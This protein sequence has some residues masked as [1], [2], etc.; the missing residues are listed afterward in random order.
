VDP[1]AVS[2]GLC[3]D[4]GSSSIARAETLRRATEVAKHYSQT[5]LV[6]IT[7]FVSPLRSERTAAREQICS[8]DR[9]FF[10]VHVTASEVTLK[11]RVGGSEP[12]MCSGSASLW[13]LQ[14]P[15]SKDGYEKPT[16]P[17]LSLDTDKLTAEE[18]VN[19]LT[20]LLEASGVLVAKQ[21]LEAAVRDQKTSRVK[22][23]RQ[24]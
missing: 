1:V 7:S 10:E 9:R 20:H 3:S 23:L 14:P 16:C 6:A 8:A 2:Q 4:L 18:C 17:D 15:K 19:K 24:S 5:C 12:S 11:T 13:Q 22:T 21:A